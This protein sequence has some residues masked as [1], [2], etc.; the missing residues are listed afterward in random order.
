[1][2]EL[3]RSMNFVLRN[4]LASLGKKEE[5]E[6]EKERERKETTQTIP[7]MHNDSQRVNETI[8]KWVLYGITVLPVLAASSLKRTR[9]QEVSCRVLIRAQCREFYQQKLTKFR[10]FYWFYGM[11]RADGGWSRVAWSNLDDL[12]LNIEEVLTV[13]GSKRECWRFFTIGDSQSRK[14]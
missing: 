11:G 12:L 9:R 8:K 3:A 6:R 13:K 4:E 5:R 10:A 1:M 7:S 2:D 14:A